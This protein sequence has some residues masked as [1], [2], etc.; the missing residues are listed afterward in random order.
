MEAEFPAVGAVIVGVIE[1]DAVVRDRVVVG[2]AS[3]G[4][5]RCADEH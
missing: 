1:L 4:Q 2:A 5:P 3:D